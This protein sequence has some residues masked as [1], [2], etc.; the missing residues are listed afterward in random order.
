MS[1]TA[2]PPNTRPAAQSTSTSCSASTAT[3]PPTPASSCP[4]RPASPPPTCPD[5]VH[6]AASTITYRTPPHP[7]QP[8]GWLVGWG[9]QTDVRIITI[10]GTRTITD[11]AVASYL[12]KYSTKGTETTGHASARLT[13]DT[14][15][16]YANPDGTHPERLIHACWTLGRHPDHTSLRRW[17]H[18]LGF[19]GHFLTKA[20]R[21]SITFHDLRQAR[22]IYRR[23]HDTGPE[24]RPI[25]PAD[26]DDRDDRDDQD[27]T[28]IIGTLTYAGTGWQTSGDALL[29]NTAADQAR[30]RRQAGHDALTD[31]Y[32]STV[33]G[34]Q[35]A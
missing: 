32:N 4:R 5:A 11:V 2:R 1:R 9:T 26:R 24:H 33:P 25:H 21:Y 34:R 22:I 28:L 14:I 7:A 19:G 23:T 31:E 18:M 15:D 6:H 35:A 8:G 27:T 17:A 3:T 16:L 20:R 12:A 10:R 29:A 30:K 13:P